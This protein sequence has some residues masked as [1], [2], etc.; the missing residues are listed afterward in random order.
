MSK[1]RQRG[2]ATTATSA[3]TYVLAAAVI[4]AFIAS[5]AWFLLRVAHGPSLHTAL[6][7]LLAGDA[8][9]A[10][11]QLISLEARMGLQQAEIAILKALAVAALPT[12]PASE[13]RSV[14]A[15]LQRFDASHGQA[16]RLA[17]AYGDGLAQRALFKKPRGRESTPL[18]TGMLERAR[19][20]GWVGQAAA[21]LASDGVTSALNASV[22]VL[23]RRPLVVT[24]DDFAEPALI[25][26]AAQELEGRVRRA[27]RSPRKV[28]VNPN[29]RELLA[30]LQALANSETGSTG[31][32]AQWAA[33]PAGA[34]CASL[35]PALTARVGSASWS[36]SYLN[37]GV[38][39][40]IDH[41]DGAIASALGVGG[42]LNAALQNRQVVLDTARGV[43]E[44]RT[45][46]EASHGGGGSTPTSDSVDEAYRWTTESQGLYY[47]APDSA[48]SASAALP[49][50]VGNG[51]VVGSP[52]AYQLHTDCEDFGGGRSEMRRQ[53]EAAD[54]TVSALLYLSSPA[55]GGATSFPLVGLEAYPRAGRLLVFETL[56]EHGWCDPL[57]AHEGLPPSA[58][59]IPKLVLQKWVLG[60]P[61]PKGER[62]GGEG[63]EE[64]ARISHVMCDLNEVCRTFLRPTS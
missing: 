42:T 37:R 44:A 22:R 51:A 57:A 50:S 47:P 4:V 61:R 29:A 6:A 17:R 12:L 15:Q 18:S 24:V 52:S 60:R 8:S 2:T 20:G 64:T 16:S 23:S 11:Q 36:I 63:V 40:A 45:T 33:G 32:R 7:T 1:R 10:Y 46:E 25:E 56:D 19:L 54:R 49:P 30:E 13:R 43:G 35:T 59:T 27:L 58:G 26:A 34:P 31:R 41:L 14:E 28:C 48:S 53:S 9:A 39:S 3:H 21:Q 55:A 38:S 62:R 5:L